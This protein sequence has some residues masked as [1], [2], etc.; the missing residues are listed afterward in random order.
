LYS[1]EAAKRLTQS[2]SIV[3]KINEFIK[4]NGIKKESIKEVIRIAALRSSLPE[5]SIFARTLDN[6]IIN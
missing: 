4:F 2:D 5:D 1:S 3:N 6:I